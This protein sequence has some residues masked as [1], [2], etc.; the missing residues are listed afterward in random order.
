MKTK[1]LIGVSASL[2]VVAVVIAGWFFYGRAVPVKE[3]HHHAGFVVYMDGQKQ[4]FSHIRHM[5]LVPCGEHSE[6]PTKEE[7]QLEKAHLH[8]S[9]G[10][11]VHVHRAGATWGD[12]FKNMNFTYDHTLEVIGYRD[13]HPIRDIL[14]QEIVANDS[15]IFV[16]GSQE[17]VVD[18]LPNKVTLNRIAEVEQKSELCGSNHD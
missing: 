2:S 16:V 12:L 5:S 14:K 7:E 3:V 1:I 11:V 18:Y 15:L 17:K 6:K 10:D 8:D 4:D 9:N 13:D